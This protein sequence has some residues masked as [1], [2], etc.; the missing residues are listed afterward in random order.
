MKTRKRKPVASSTLECWEGCLKNWINPNIGQLPL[1]A[2]NN[3]KVKP[4]V[5]LMA[6]AGLS[7]KSIDNYVQA[8]KMVVA[9]ATDTEGQPLYPANGILSYWACLLSS[10]NS[11]IRRVSHRR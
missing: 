10:S 1:S 3:A 5:T 8:V 7:P 6:Q 9:S 2:V 11:K 4:I